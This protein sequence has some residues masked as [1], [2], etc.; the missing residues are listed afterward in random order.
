MTRFCLTLA[1]VLLT[2]VS[3]NA[4]TMVSGVGAITS[5]LNNNGDPNNG[6][7]VLTN[8]GT[9]L[10]GLYGTENLGYL[11]DNYP[12][13][14][15]WSDNLIIKA[16]A[17][18]NDQGTVSGADQ[19]ALLGYFDDTFSTGFRNEVGFGIWL[20][21]PNDGRMFLQIG[22]N[23]VGPIG[24]WAGSF[25][26]NNPFDINLAAS[27]SGGTLMVTGTISDGSTTIN[28]NESSGVDP[29]ETLVAFG[30]SSS[31]GPQSNTFRNFGADFS[32]VMYISTV[33]EPGTIGL[34]LIG[35]SAIGFR[36]RSR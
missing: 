22:G 5:G 6:G 31:F 7:T 26:R 33:P 14:L 24:D 35:L 10:D 19:A 15:G 25:G 12:G 28:V 27:E 3:A 32:D 20:L 17:E 23:T 36:R 8:T 16:T 4:G 30:T 34:I 21:G 9:I 18:V 13:S 11:V 2:A 1:V 29:A